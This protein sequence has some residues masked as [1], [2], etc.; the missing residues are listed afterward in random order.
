MDVAAS[1]DTFLAHRQADVVH[2]RKETLVGKEVEVVL[3][4]LPSGPKLDGENDGSVQPALWELEWAGE[5]VDQEQSALTS[6]H[7]DHLVH[8]EGP[9]VGRHLVKG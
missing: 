7:A 1:E 5:I 2:K 9:D 4:V 6:G 8:D 3:E